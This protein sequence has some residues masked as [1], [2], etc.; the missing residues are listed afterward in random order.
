MD[1]KWP[2]NTLST[3]ST[4]EIS[5][6][7][8]TGSEEKITTSTAGIQNGIFHLSVEGLH[9]SSPTISVKALDQPSGTKPTAGVGKT[10]KCKKV[11]KRK[12]HIVKVAWGKKCPKGYKSVK[13]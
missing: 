13:P 7:D 4:F 2:G 11:V 3:S 5:V 10:L 9:Y 1:C 12:T 8:E 6:V